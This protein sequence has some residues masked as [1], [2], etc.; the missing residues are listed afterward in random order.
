MM[1]PI[2]WWWMLLALPASKDT[3]QKTTEHKASEIIQSSHPSPNKSV[4]A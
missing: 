4:G 2:V 1:S 3:R